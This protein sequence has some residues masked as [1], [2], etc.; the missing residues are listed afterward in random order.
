MG[1]LP[2][3]RTKKMLHEKTGL[4]L[5]QSQPCFLEGSLTGFWGGMR[6]AS[7]GMTVE[8]LTG[9]QRGI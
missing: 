9:F 2:C 3:Q 5:S 1:D 7:M 6:S 4:S 8:D